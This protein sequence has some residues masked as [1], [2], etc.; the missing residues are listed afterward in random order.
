ME[1]GARLRGYLM[2]LGAAVCWGVMATVAKL[3]FRGQ[4][5]DPLTLVVIRADLAA[6]V[7]LGG[8]AVFRPADLRLP[9]RD[10]RAAAVIGVCGLLTNNF[11]YFLTL[12]LTGVAT[13]LLLQYQA[14]VLVALY[15]VCVDRQRLPAR[16]LLA[17]ALALAGCAL[18][19]RAYDPS[20][21]RLGL[22]GILAGLGT[23]VAFAFY[24]LASRAALK[25]IQAWPLLAY[26]YLAAGLAGSVAVPPWRILAGGYDA[27][28]W[29]A[30]GAIA[31]AGTVIPFGLFIGGLRY[32]PPAQASVVSMLEPAVAALAAYAVLGET[33]LPL[34]LVGGV[35]VL[36]GVALVER[37]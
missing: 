32:L 1:R 8:L 12:S 22:P 23:A 26:G 29:A 24:I 27:A 13:A 11:L 7:L 30:F 36:V 18:V 2:V 35:L 20:L 21:L 37:R 33:L 5:V 25:R 6:L 14:P 9:W 3:L 4:T 15:T 17:L 34:Q 10:L 16:L 28:A 19:V 31:L